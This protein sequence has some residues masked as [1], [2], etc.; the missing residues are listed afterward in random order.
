MC[1][2]GGLWPWNLPIIEHHDLDANR[3]LLKSRGVVANGQGDPA[4]TEGLLGAS[5]G[6]FRRELCR[7]ISAGLRELSSPRPQ[8]ERSAVDDDCGRLHAG[9]IPLG[10]FSGDAALRLGRPTAL[11]VTRCGFFI[12]AIIAVVDAFHVISLLLLAASFFA[13]KVSSRSHCCICLGR[14]FIK[15]IIALVVTFL[16]GAVLFV[17]G[18][19]GF[20]R[21]LRLAQ[22]GG[23]GGFANYQ[24][25]TGIA[26]IAVLL[27]TFLRVRSFSVLATGL[28]SGLSGLNNWLHRG[29]YIVLRVLQGGSCR[30]TD[31]MGGMAEEVL[32]GIFRNCCLQP[33]CQGICLELPNCC[34][35]EARLLLLFFFGFG[36][37]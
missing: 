13:I 29:S 3:N 19:G 2:S 25:L 14:V 23:H 33:V 22:V 20:H 30:F 35:I 24:G 8:R 18:F 26:F 37:L 32:Q 15:D 21:L 9:G 17:A 10:H 1:H 28:L 36:G 4:Q 27:R 6:D 11:R 16:I 31:E 7:D 5:C 34:S 12:R